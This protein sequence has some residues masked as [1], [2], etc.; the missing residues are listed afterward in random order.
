M[1]YLREE[2]SSK[3]SLSG[4]CTYFIWRSKLET[5]FNIT[6]NGIISFFYYGFRIIEINHM[7]IHWDLEGKGVC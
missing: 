1:V 5:Y 7:E 2:V 3:V 4:L 6:L